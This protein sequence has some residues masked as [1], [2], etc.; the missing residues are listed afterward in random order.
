MRGQH[1]CFQTMN[2]QVDKSK[3]DKLVTDIE[4]A[5]KGLGTDEKKLINAT[6]CCTAMER[7]AIS[8][9]YRV[10]NNKA[11]ESLLKSEL[12][13][14]IKKLMIGMYTDRYVYWAE[15]INDA[16][17]GLGTN[18][19]KLIDLLVSC[20]DAEYA[21]VDRVYTQLYK[22]SVYEA[23][24]GDCG[25]SDWGKLMK[26]WIKN[27]SVCTGNP[28]ALAE[29]L[30]KAAK[31]MGTDEKVFIE[32]LTSV[33]HQTYQ[34]IDAEYSRLYQKALRSVIKSEFSG[35]AE[36]AFLAVHDYLVDPVRFVA[37]MLYLSMKGLGTNDDKLI[38]TTVLHSDWCKPR[39]AQ[40]YKAMGF[41]DLAKDIKG[42]TSGK[43]EYALLAFWGL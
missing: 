26:A 27:E 6:A 9:S 25:K 4:V 11:L 31:G 32:I 38:Y 14:N 35:K 16:V 10:K 41:G 7:G 36:Y 20:S 15:Q 8:E 21:N 12:S 3:I 33:N 37:N 19:K 5:C 30:H 22:E 17:K 28:T 43:Y 2:L 23:L 1:P 40:G 29:S 39:I 34:A 24:S 13:N 42:D 18:E